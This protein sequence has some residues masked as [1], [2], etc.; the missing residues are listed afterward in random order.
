MTVAADLEAVYVLHTRA[1]RDTSLLCELFSQSHGRVAAVARS[2]RGPRARFRGLLQ[3]FSPLQVTWRGRGEMVS[4]QQVEQLRRPYQL[5]AQKLF[6]GLYVNELLVYLLERDDAH[7]QLFFYYQSLLET[8]QHADE[9]SKI[10]S[11][12]RVFE[13]RLLTELGYQLLL[14]KEANSEQVVLAEKNYLFDPQFGPSA[15]EYLPKQMDNLFS[16]HS[17]LALAAEDLSSAQSRRDAKRL[18]R[19]ALRQLLG[20]RVLHSRELWR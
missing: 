3:L 7:P 11:A 4:L 17:L 13:K 6:S 14:D 18:M 1:Y 2:A 20:N 9:P 10:E 12:L 16:G 8:L 15:I 19:L 5:S